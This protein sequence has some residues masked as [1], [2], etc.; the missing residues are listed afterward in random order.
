M[1]RQV[2]CWAVTYMEACLGP[3]NSKGAIEACIHGS[4]PTA[5]FC[6][7]CQ[8]SMEYL[9]TMFESRAYGLCMMHDP[10]ACCAQACE[11]ACNL[12]SITGW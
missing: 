9:L 2:D 12:L 11:H 8:H 3:L 10:H 1:E 7:G 5:A 4:A 6:P